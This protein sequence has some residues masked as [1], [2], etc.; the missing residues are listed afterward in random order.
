MFRD[1]FASPAEG[2]GPEGTNNGQPIL[3][4]EVT[5]GEFKALLDYF[6]LPCVAYPQA[7]NNN[8]IEAAL[9]L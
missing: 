5:K 4:P 1:M 7:H 2:T 3:L 9:I 8:F 6:Y